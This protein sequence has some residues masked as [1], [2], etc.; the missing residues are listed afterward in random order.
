M[1]TNTHAQRLRA[2][3]K[4]K[5]WSLQ[6]VEQHS[7]GRWKA[8]VVGSYERA[9]RAISLKKAIQ[10]MEFYQV[11]ITELFPDI[12]TQISPKSLCLNLKTLNEVQDSK[13]LTLKRFT[14][15]ISGLRK[16]WNGQMLTIRTN[17]LQFLAMLLNENESETLDWLVEKE[18][19]TV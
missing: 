1:D 6:D 15:R 12:T 2:I 3:R 4:S 5:G 16:D 13:A 18:L 7:N 9:D 10:L 8:V 19:I 17:D 14:N 11:P